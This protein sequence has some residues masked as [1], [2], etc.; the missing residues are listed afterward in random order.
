MIVGRTARP[1]GCRRQISTLRI[2]GTLCTA[3][4]PHFKHTFDAMYHTAPLMKQSTARRRPKCV[5]Y[6]YRYYLCLVHHLPILSL[7]ALKKRQNKAVCR[8]A[9]MPPDSG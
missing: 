4:P 3:V 9:A 2:L 6:A 8:C 5:S 1:I 7:S